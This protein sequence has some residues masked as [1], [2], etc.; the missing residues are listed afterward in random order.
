MLGQQKSSCNDTNLDS[1][2]PQI[3]PDTA[4]N[5]GVD[6]KVLES[7]KWSSN[8]VINGDGELVDA[9]V[10]GGLLPT[11]VTRDLKWGVPV[12]ID[13]ADDKSMEGKVLCKFH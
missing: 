7:R 3:R 8:S 11:P 2:L 1:Q 6:Q 12:P 5:R 13:S 10:K 9:R 4:S